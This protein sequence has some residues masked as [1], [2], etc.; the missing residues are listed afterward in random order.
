MW[1]GRN[2]G[3]VR[4]LAILRAFEQGGRLTVLGLSELFGV[5]PRTIRRDIEALEA[6]GVPITNEPGVNC[7]Q[8]GEW[9][10]CR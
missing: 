6:A 3:L 10:L 9:W 8:V 4:A 1:R 7:W 2:A 5:S